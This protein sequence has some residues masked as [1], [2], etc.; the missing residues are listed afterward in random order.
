MTDVCSKGFPITSESRQ[1]GKKKERGGDNSK[2]SVS[3]AGLDY[4]SL[5]HSSQYYL[6]RQ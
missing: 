2:K 6:V 4:A 5:L 3:G 1:K